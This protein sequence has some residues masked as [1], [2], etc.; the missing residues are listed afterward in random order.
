MAS[1]SPVPVTMLPEP[2]GAS[3]EDFTEARMASS[4]AAL[5]VSVSRGLRPPSA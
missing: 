5:S 2:K 4:E 1:G 3:L